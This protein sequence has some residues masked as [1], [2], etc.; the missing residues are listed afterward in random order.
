MANA[1][2]S[3]RPTAASASPGPLR[4]RQPTARP[5]TAS[6]Q[7]PIICVPRSARVRPASTAARDIGSDR[8]RSISP[9]D[10]SVTSPTA[11]PGAVPAIVIPNI[12]LIRYWW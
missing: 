5:V 10:M 6:T 3:D 12:P 7:M 9:V 1:N 11:V 4:T 8:N 2:S